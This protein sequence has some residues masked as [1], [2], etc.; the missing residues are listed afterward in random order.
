MNAIPETLEQMIDPNLTFP[1]N[2]LRAIRAL[3]RTKPWQ[4]DFDARFANLSTCLTALCEAY[5]LEPWQL[6]HTGDRAGC[7]G[8]SG[9]K[10]RLKRINLTG[11]LSVVTMLHLFAK[12][13]EGYRTVEDHGRAMRWSA[14][15]FKRC[16]P[17]SFSRC[18]LV[19]GL[20][21]ND[22]RRDE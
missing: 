20:L 5:N 17:L 11:R 21:V 14:T 1:P 16:F 2:A 7:S 10:T 22:G 15:L 9:L 18:R 19:G 8:A 12:A 6:V 4:G 13:R 3:A